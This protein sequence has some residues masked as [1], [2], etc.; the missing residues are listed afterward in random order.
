MNVTKHTRA[1]KKGKK[2]YCPKCNHS[3]KVYHFSWSAIT[4]GACTRMINKYDFNLIKRQYRSNQGRNP[5]NNKETY[6]VL[7]LAVI[8]LV[9][10][11]IVSL[12]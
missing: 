6:K 3:T 9:I 11:I 2:I 7:E 4:C 10:T 8:L 5:Q 1:G 12:L